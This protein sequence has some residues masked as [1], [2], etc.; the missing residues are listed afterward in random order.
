MNNKS[1]VGPSIWTE[2]Y[3]KFNFFNTK[4][5]LHLLSLIPI[6]TYLD[7]HTSVRGKDKP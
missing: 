6:V 3:C 7:S 1:S 5:I 4:S 2:K